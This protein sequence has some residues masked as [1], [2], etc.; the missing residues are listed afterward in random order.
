[1]AKPF[2]LSDLKKPASFS[3]FVMSLLVPACLHAGVGNI[4]EIQVQE[5]I[6]ILHAGAETVVFQVCRPNI[7]RI[8]FC[9]PGA[10]EPD[11]LIVPRKKWPKV[12]VQIDTSGDPVVITSAA[13]RLAITRRPLRFTLYDANG[14]QLLQ[15]TPAVGLHENGVRLRVTG[16]HFYG[17]HNNFTGK[18]SKNHGGTIS[19]GMQGHAG[20]PFVWTTAGYG[21]LM[22]S[23]SG[24][25]KIA[26]G[27]LDFTVERARRFRGVAKHSAPAPAR[28][29]LELYILVGTPR[30]IFTA[31][32][33]ISGAAPLFPKFAFGFLNTEWGLDQN[34]LLGDINTYRAKGIPLDAYILDFDWM[35]YGEDNY[36]EF[37]W[38]PKFPDGPSGRLK[39]IT[40][41]LGVKL[42]GI[43]KPRVHLNTEQGRFCQREGYFLDSEIDYFSR[44]KVG[45]LNF[46]LP[47]VRQWFFDSFFERCRS[48]A[49]GIIGYWNDE[50]DSYG[51]NLMFLQMQ[52]ANY[53]G[54]R[55]RN[56]QRV[57]SINRNFFLGAQRYAYGHWSGDI[58]TGFEAMARQR[59]FML[60][61][62]ALGS[63]WWGMDIGGF[64]GRP[65]PENYI[66]WMQFG[67]FVPIFRVHGTFNQ[68]REPWQYG[69]QAEAIVKKYIRLRYALLP[70][71]YSYAWENHRTGLALVRPLLWDYPDDPRVAE[72]YSQWLVGDYLLITPV[73]EPQIDSLSVY[74]PAGQ[75]FD[76]WT[77]KLYDGSRQVTVPVTLQDIPI[78][79]K[80]GAIVPMA[81]VGRFVDDPQA[82]LNP[83][84]LHCYPHGAGAFTL[85]EDDGLTYD[86]EQGLFALTA[87]TLRDDGDDLL[88]QLGERQGRFQPRPRDFL[89]AVHALSQLPALVEQDGRHLARQSL[90][91]IWKGDAV[92]WAYDEAAAILYVR[93]PDHGGSQTLRI[94]R[95]R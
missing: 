91:R 48:F 10:T 31:M 75:W 8:S 23:D 63:A 70:Y 81:P 42:F 38:G 27:Q 3:Q 79:V 28:F 60:S 72:L 6:L 47:E 26:G 65:D 84:T 62:I 2:P 56:N 86:Y 49:L 21:L 9:P 71:L 61:S 33:A 58:D 92:G 80:A 46:H 77:E 14:R 66:R 7:L 18:L 94:R 4:T 45:R 83:L 43:R 87:M 35:A 59:L 11:T 22:N 29:A 40:D 16:E 64:K 37:R 24:H 15:E 88:L 13:L 82:P 90:D 34:E 85:Y 55:R 69:P 39:Q 54:Q 44:K 53:E 5:D 1:M 57:W 12:S 93:L 50:A 36:G 89:V 95:Q 73:V 19:A 76:Y 30:E 74:L 68:E 51:G 17:I 20:A 41:S 78:F 25:I 32:T 67:A 52:R